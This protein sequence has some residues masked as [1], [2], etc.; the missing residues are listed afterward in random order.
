MLK[1]Q[2][3]EKLKKDDKAWPLTY[4]ESQG[5]TGDR[6]SCQEKA[7]CTVEHSARNKSKEKKREAPEEQATKILN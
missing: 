5:S 6:H 7:E 1:I 3:I 2:F 4:R